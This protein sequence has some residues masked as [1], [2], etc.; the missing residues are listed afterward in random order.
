MENSTKIYLGV[1]AAALVAFLLLKNKAAAQKPVVP[2]VPAKEDCPAGQ[3]RV[4]P[5]CITA[6]C[7]SYCMP[8]IIPQF[9][10]KENQSY[11]EDS[12]GG[13]VGY[14]CPE[15]TKPCVNNPNKCVNPDMI[16][17]KDPCS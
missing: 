16:Y 6:P 13:Y 17:E 4:Q 11:D 12:Y 1:G 5:N 3:R 7:P 14:G 10:V 2:P 15:G 8:N 9:P